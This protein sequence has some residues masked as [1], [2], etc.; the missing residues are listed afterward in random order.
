MALKTPP[1]RAKGIYQLKAPWSVSPTLI[2]ECIAIRSFADFLE[3]GEDVFK[4]I[5]EPKGLSQ[6]TFEADRA[7]GAHIITLVSG[8]QPIIHVP[9]TYIEAYPLQNTVAYKTVVVS[10]SLGPLPDSLDLTFLKTQLQGVVSDVI[11]VTPEVKLHVLPALDVITDTQHEALEA[12]RQAAI[13][14]R[15]TDRARVLEL[16]AQVAAMTQQIQ[17]LEQIIIDNGYANPAP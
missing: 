15:K 10:V 11:G 9:D 17:T 7:L 6:A 1:L 5:Y 3:K 8:T 12:A 13:A 14:N 16:Q 4:L 2:Y